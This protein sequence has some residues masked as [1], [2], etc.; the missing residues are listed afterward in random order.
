[1]FLITI[2][3]IFW[4]LFLNV[5]TYAIGANKFNILEN[6][7]KQYIPDQMMLIDYNNVKQYPI[8]IKPV[9]CTKLS[10]G[11]LILN[12]RNEVETFIQE[13]KS[14][15]NE[16]MIQDLVNDDIE[17]GVLVEKYPFQKYVKII[18]ITE[19]T[20]KT[21]IRPHCQDLNCIPRDD[22]IPYLEDH[23]LLY[24]HQLNFLSLVLF[25]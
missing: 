10:K 17:L 23:Y 18:S 14:L 24:L 22:L 20:N 9:V 6:F 4:I 2:F 7:P 25:L 12:S 1:M 16:Y 11:I 5:N 19:K 3:Y 8:I 15:V 13:N 21:I